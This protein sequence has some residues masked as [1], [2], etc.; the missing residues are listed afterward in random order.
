MTLGRIDCLPSGV[1]WT[2]VLGALDP[3][4][5]EAPLLDVVDVH[6]FEADMTA[7]ALLQHLDDLAYGRLLEAERPVE[8]DRAIE[9][10]LVK[11]VIGRA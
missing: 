3:L 10:G 11:A 2:G 8:P 7:V 4:L 5:D 9:V 6:V 1:N